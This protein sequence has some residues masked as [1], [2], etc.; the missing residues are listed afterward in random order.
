MTLARCQDLLL[1]VVLRLDVVESEL[2]VLLK[3]AVVALDGHLGVGVGRVQVLE[4]N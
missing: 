2:L 1:S 4:V 3:G